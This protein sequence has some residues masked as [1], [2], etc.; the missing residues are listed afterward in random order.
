MAMI[1]FALL[2]SEKAMLSEEE[3]RLRVQMAQEF[4]RLPV[5][6]QWCPFGFG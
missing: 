1:F 3:F 4:T 2:L 6:L 5:L